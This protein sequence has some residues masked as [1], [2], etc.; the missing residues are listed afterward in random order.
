MMR[1][2]QKDSI[3]NWC[4]RGLRWEQF[5]VG[6]IITQEAWEKLYGALCKL[7]DYEDTERTPDEI[8]D[9]KILKGWI[10]PSERLPKKNPCYCLVTTLKSPKIEM[11]WYLSGEWYW[12][13]SDQLIRDVVAWMP[14]PEL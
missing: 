11:A 8:M 7:K 2:I 1:L 13:N 3:G 10:P 14:L 5:Q 12:N 4:L 6:Q 9:G